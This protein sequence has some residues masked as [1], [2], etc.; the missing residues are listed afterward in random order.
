MIL[1]DEISHQ[2]PI[3]KSLRTWKS[4]SSPHQWNKNM[5][6]DG[7][8]EKQSWWGWTINPQGWLVV[9]TRHI[10]EGGQALSM[11]GHKSS[12]MATN[13]KPYTWW[14]GNEVKVWVWQ[15]FFWKCAAVKRENN[16]F[17]DEI[18]LNWTKSFSINWAVKM[19]ILGRKL[20]LDKPSLLQLCLLPVGI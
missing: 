20:V 14:E 4:L 6:V 9:V 2:P 18:Q 8:G 3:D 1:V 13:R 17:H 12:Q 15:F 10:G 16:L 7:Y 5:F 19:L 11:L